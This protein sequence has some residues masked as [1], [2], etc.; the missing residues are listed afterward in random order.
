[1]IR[2]D[3]KAILGYRKLTA[4]AVDEICTE[5]GIEPDD[6]QRKM[7]HNLVRRKERDVLMEKRNNL[8]R[9]RSELAASAGKQS[10]NDKKTKTDDYKTPQKSIAKDYLGLLTK[11]QSRARS[12]SNDKSK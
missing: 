11:S 2:D 8:K 4:T 9:G 1:M 6:G 10:P 7:L 3:L 5:I 12:T